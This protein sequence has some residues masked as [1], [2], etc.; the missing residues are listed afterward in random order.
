M[1]TAGDDW[2]SWLALR[3]V[4]GVGPIV[5]QGLLR[6]FGEPGA[7]FRASAHALECAGVRPEVARAI[8]AFDGWTTI[9]A[10]LGEL[11]RS[12]ARLVKW[13]D[14]SYPANLREIHDPPPFLFVHG[15]LLPR[16]LMAVALVGSRNVSAY[17]MRMTRELAEGL[18]RYGVTVVSGLARGTDAAAHWTTMRAGGRT[19][20]VMG[21]GIDVVY[22]SEH[23]ALFRAISQ[24]GAVVTELPMG[25]QP[26]AENF[27]NRNRIISGLALGTVIVEAA[28]KSGSLI[29]AT[30]AAE[31]GRD[32]FAVP[33]AVGERTR[34]THRLIREGA[35]LTQCAEDV[36]EEIAPQLL[37][38]VAPAAPVELD[39]AEAAVVACMRH[40]TLH[41]DQIIARSAM[42]PAAVL[43]LLLA[44][45]LKGVV[46]QLPGKH[47]AASAIDVPRN[48]A[49]E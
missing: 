1:A 46:Q 35:K 19:I 20:A 10:Q 36:L 12:G 37:T 41:I 17:G 45:E 21:S 48:P 6:S 9:D 23:H 3:A 43:Q 34:G 29:T 39:R 28:E 2:R 32:V 24:Q 16:D 33:G 4:R 31:Q 40:E 49:K 11:G 27:P 26:D 44:L 30:L 38:R 13:N 5:Y 8:R 47:F 42:P 18:V 25:A 22:P 7:V 15:D 14:A